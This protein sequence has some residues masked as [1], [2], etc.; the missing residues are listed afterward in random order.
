MELEST[1]FSLEQVIQHVTD[2]T[3]TKA[4]EKGLELSIDIGADV[5]DAL[6]GDALRLAQVLTNLIDNAIKFTERGSITLAIHRISV[7][8]ERV[9]LRF[10]SRRH[11]DRL[12]RRTTATAVQPFYPG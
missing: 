2:I 12:E 1:D 5:P 4:Q 6:V 7:D 9:R 11:R 8:S 10:D 3:A